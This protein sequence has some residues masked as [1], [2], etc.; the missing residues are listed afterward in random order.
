MIVNMTSRWRRNVGLKATAGFCSALLFLGAP[1][2]N[3]VQAVP[4]PVA[5]PTTS[6]NPQE[7][8]LLG[9]AITAAGAGDL[10]QAQL[11]YQ[12]LL[13]SYPNSPLR[14]QVYFGL[15]QINQQQQ[16]YA[17]AA[18]QYQKLL[19]KFPKSPWVKQARRALAE[20]YIGLGQYDSAV[21]VLE[22]ERS[23]SGDSV[24]RGELT[25]RI[26]DV[27][28]M[29]KD[30]V[31]AMIELLKKESNEE[32]EKRAIEVRVQKLLDQSSQGELEE[33][34]HDFPK[35]YPG[36][37]AM[38]RLAD[39]H[40]SGRE[41]FEAERD[42]R[43]FLSI[44]PK[45]RAVPEV[46]GK[47][48][49][50]RQMYLSHRYLIGALLPMSGR[51]KPFGHQVL[52][53]IR[54]AMDSVPDGVP[55][56]SIGVVVKDTEADP[57]ALQS[58]L[59][60][61]AREYR[62]SA[63]IGP[64]LS[65]QVA[66]AAPK[67]DAYRIPL[68]TPTAS[69]E[70]AKPWR[71]VLRNSITTRQQARA[72]A[73]YAVNAL[74]R[75]RFCILYSDDAY[76]AEMTRAFTEEVSRLGGEIIAQASYDPQ[77]TDFGPQIRYL[78]KTDLSKYGVLGPAPEQSGEIREY[79]PGFDG[80]FIPGDY[81]QVGLIAAQLAFFDIQGVTLLGTS[82]WDSPELFRIG[83]RY[84]DGGIFVDGFF[85]GSSDPAIR[86]FVERYRT[87]YGEEPTLLSAQAYDSADM[88]L[89]SIQQGATSG[90]AVREFLGRI[91]NFPGA[92]GPISYDPDGELAK[93]LYVI[94]AKDGKFVQIN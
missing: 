67:S 11:A 8:E 50:I 17:D 63:I 47:I 93:R 46:R 64:L 6:H 42:L 23:L 89:K 59:D 2:I 90:E 14:D 80:I 22:L 62:V 30:R 56:K 79:K 10:E 85:P 76:G 29:K 19:N 4:A 81:D 75:K 60:E 35:G 78:K 74:N 52:N 31:Q 25:D 24:A 33:L 92:T 7:Q 39:L 21:T 41:Y 61:L 94:Q 1:M 69:E 9:R 57:A 40:E 65:R 34:V 70:W 82:G 87:R 84:I 51:L 88:I 68:L 45:H 3:P 71:Y 27:F 48:I 36:D 26:V 16:N 72:M 43:R 49:A 91:Q 38:L 73:A 20:A 15:A 32:A 44:F 83:G 12:L 66:A 37:A 53:G 77:A 54:L 28:L 58:G 13:T 86:S 55:E 18:V 5:E